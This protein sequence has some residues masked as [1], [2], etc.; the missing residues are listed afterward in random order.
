MCAG[1]AWHPARPTRTLYAPQGDHLVSQRR[2]YPSLSNSLE[3]PHET[4]KTSEPFYIYPL[5][6]MRAHQ[7]PGTGHGS[8]GSGRIAYAAVYGAG[9][10]MGVWAS[11][12][13]S[14]LLRRS[15]G[16]LRPVYTGVEAPT[17]AGVGTRVF[18]QRTLRAGERTG[19]IIRKGEMHGDTLCGVDR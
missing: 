10:R 1:D 18:Y 19:V 11:T 5:I 13:K 17:P 6:P 9:Q 12:W 16:Q 2:A 14:V 15:C 8:A 7:E 3:V 4:L